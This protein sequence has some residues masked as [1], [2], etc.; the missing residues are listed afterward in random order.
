M[1]TDDKRK[2]MFFFFA[3]YILTWLLYL[4]IGAE[5]SDWFQELSLGSD[6]S[7]VPRNHY[8]V[9]PC[10]CFDAYLMQ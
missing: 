9:L 10:C 8:K 6:A 5:T 4:M 3:P 1:S 7:E 2:Y